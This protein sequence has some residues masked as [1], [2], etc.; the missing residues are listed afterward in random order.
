M[1]HRMATADARKNFAGMV[2]R[3]AKGERIKLTRY[4][5]TIAILIPKQDLDKLEECEASGAAH[6][7]RTGARRKARRS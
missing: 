5:K 1:A 7:A 3:S 4:D 2:K 6:G